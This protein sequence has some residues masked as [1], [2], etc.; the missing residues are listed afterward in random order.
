VNNDKKSAADLLGPWVDPN[1]ESGLVLRCKAAWDKPLEELTN[2]ELATFLDQT[3]C[4]EHVLPI[5]QNRIERKIDD[6]TEWYEGHLKAS[7]EQVT[8]KQRL[9]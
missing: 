6:E 7:I 4:P 2:L 8:C 1:W 3:I 9:N 5:A